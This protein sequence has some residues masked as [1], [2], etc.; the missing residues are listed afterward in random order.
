MGL[1]Q[2]TDLFRLKAGATQGV[3]DSGTHYSVLWSEMLQAVSDHFSIPSLVDTAGLAGALAPYALAASVYTQAAADAAFAPIAHNHVI[4]DITDFTDNS[5]NWDTAHGWGDH[6][7]AGYLLPADIANSG[8]WDTAFSWGN[9]ASAGY[10][11]AVPSGTDAALIGGGSVSNAEFAYLA[12]VTSDIQSQIDSKAAAVHTHD[13]SEIASGTIDIAR[14]PAA[15][16]QAPVV[17][18]GAIADLTAPQQA[19]VLEGTT[20]VTTDGRAWMYS[21]SGDKLLEASYVE[22]ADKTPEWSVVANKPTEFTPAAHTHIIGDITGLQA[23]LDGKAA[24]TNVANWD[25]AFA[26]GDHGAAGYADGTNE[27]NWDA[28]FGW[29]DHAAAGYAAA[30]HSH[31][32]ADVT[33]LQAALDGKL[34][35]DGVTFTV[36]NYVFDVDQA[37]GASEDGYVLEYDHA[38]GQI[39]LKANAGGGGGTVASSDETIDGDWDFIRDTAGLLRYTFQNSNTAAEQQTD[40]H[41]STVGTVAADLYL[42]VNYTNGLNTFIDSRPRAGGNHEFRF[43]GSV[44]SYYSATQWV[45]NE[46][47]V[48]TG[49]LAA[50]EHSHPTPGFNWKSYQ[51]ASGNL[52]WTV[53]GT[54]GAE[55]RLFAD[56]TDHDGAGTYLQVGDETVLTAGSLINLNAGAYA[57]T[58]TIGGAL[59]HTASIRTLASSG[60]T[61]INVIAANDYLD[62]SGNNHGIG[63]LF[64][65]AHGGINTPENYKAFRAAVGTTLTDVF[66]VTAEGLGYFD[67]GILVGAT[68]WNDTDS[69]VEIHRTGGAPGLHIVQNLSV[70]GAAIDLSNTIDG[71]RWRINGGDSQIKLRD[72][73]NLSDAYTIDTDGTNVI[74]HNFLLGISGDDGWVRA[75]AQG[76]VTE[77]AVIAANATEDAALY[78]GD[79][80]DNAR[81]GLYYDTS[82]NDLFVR[83][84]NN[85][86]AIRV[87]G[88]NTYFEYGMTHFVAPSD[89]ATVLRVT[90]NNNRS[91]N[92]VSPLDASGN[93]PWSWQTGNAFE[94][95]V[96]GVV[97][98][99]CVANGDVEIGSDAAERNLT[100][101]ASSSASYQVMVSGT[102]VGEINAS[103]TTWL[104]IN[105]SVAKNIYTP[106]MI[107]A[108]GG[109]QVDA[110]EMLTSDAQMR[111]NDTKR[112]YW[113]NGN[114]MEMWSDGTNFIMQHGSGSS[115]YIRNSSGT[116][117]FL[118]N[119]NSNYIRL[120]DSS[121]VDF[122]SGNDF[123]MFHNG[124]N[125]YTDMYTGDWYIRDNTTNRFLFNDNGEFSATGNIKAFQSISDINVKENVERIKDPL[126]KIDMM[127][128]ILFDYI[129]EPQRGRQTGVIAQQVQQA[130]PEA[131]YELTDK[132]RKFFKTKAKLG[133][134]E[135]KLVGLLI[136]G[137]R[138]LKGRVEALEAER[139]IQRGYN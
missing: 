40:I 27:A 103:D 26:W 18:S 72:Q 66:Y 125:M 91:T 28:A 123:R 13:A 33:G 64:P 112:F 137:I 75:R 99:S 50:I 15:V 1:P 17:S 136:E 138:A 105:Q 10:L 109:F 139:G 34:S 87:D 70:H 107:R 90:T 38:A 35:T 48:F 6:G 60:R 25:A 9:H 100:L 111:L 49:A 23:T 79:T 106:R 71:S 8:N 58:E 117:K 2:A 3:P 92:L 57:D 29:G 59:Q 77:L 63:W 52:I 118:L 134:H 21:G 67:R 82:A 22:M 12:N 69:Q 110:I 73:A 88:T 127:D 32:I 122:G 115:T 119:A 130:V 104:R 46:K 97:S 47:I 54:G 76:T 74:H 45:M 132:D 51:E 19:D 81:A 121:R 98:L 36:G 86:N 37:V 24:N 5:S 102:L 89:G 93:N 53:D 96:D 101:H 95:V 68:T 83:G 39:M 128:G 4:A 41:I 30:A 20:V 16:F 135:D 61:G 44:I 65:Y 94:W 14:L 31:A 120:Q 43:E 113:G 85:T 126:E 124:S 133:V 7:A 56:G 116:T 78:F 129:G 11:T 84:Y 55:M 114:D 80:T 131:V 108:D 42:G 62:G